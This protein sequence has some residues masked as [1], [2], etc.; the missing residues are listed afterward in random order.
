[1]ALINQFQI[2]SQKENAVTNNVL[3]ML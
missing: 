1:M 2:Y 3:L